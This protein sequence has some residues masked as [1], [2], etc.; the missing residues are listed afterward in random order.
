LGAAAAHQ[1]H[2]HRQIFGLRLNFTLNIMQIFVAGD[3]DIQ[4][5]DRLLGV[6]PLVSCSLMLA[7]SPFSTA[8]GW[9]TGTV[10]GA[11]RQCPSLKVTRL[12]LLLFPF[13][14]SSGRWA[15]RCSGYVRSRRPPA[16]GEYG[17]AQYSRRGKMAGREGIQRA[18]IDVANRIAFAGADGGQMAAGDDRQ[19]TIAAQGAGRWYC[20]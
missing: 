9:V 20:C 7:K 14:Q 18:D 6:P 17:R 15:S 16:P 5:D 13:H 1:Q 11:L 4:P 3:F 10:S 8:S 2:F 12:T 19:R